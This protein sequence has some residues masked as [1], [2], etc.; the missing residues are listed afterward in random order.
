M[1]F[2]TNQHLSK[3]AYNQHSEILNRFWNYW[4]NS[5]IT[6]EIIQ[7]VIRIMAQIVILNLSTE[8]RV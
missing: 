4:I 2:K 7:T 6:E 8:L 1:F 3:L 5:E